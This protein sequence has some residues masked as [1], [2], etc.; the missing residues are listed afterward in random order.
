MSLRIN[1]E[2]LAQAVARELGQ[3]VFQ[4]IVAGDD[5]SQPKPHPEA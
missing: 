4:A 5:V 3:P 2:A 1:A